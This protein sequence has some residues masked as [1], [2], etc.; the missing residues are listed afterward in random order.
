MIL[1]NLL[2]AMMAGTFA[3]LRTNAQLMAEYERAKLILHMEP[4]LGSLKMKEAQGTLNLNWSSTNE[5]RQAVL[6]QIAIANA[7][8]A[9]G[10]HV[11]RM[12]FGSM[13]SRLSGRDGPVYDGAGRASADTRRGSGHPAGNYGVAER[14]ATVNNREGSQ[15]QK[16]EAAEEKSRAGQRQRL[17]QRFWQMW[18][19]H[20][21]EEIYP[22][23]LHILMPASNEG[24]AG[25]VSDE[26]KPGETSGGAGSDELSRMRRQLSKVEAMLEGLVE[27]M[28]ADREQTADVSSASQPSQHSTPNL[29][30]NFSKRVGSLLKGAVPQSESLPAPGRRGAVNTGPIIEVGGHAQSHRT[31]ATTSPAAAPGNFSFR[32]WDNRKTHA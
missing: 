8:V 6:N 12:S 10:R 20:P 3:R 21:P 13:I 16:P 18:Q 27:H 4:S 25:S 29:P 24:W 14:S 15:R 31:A 17:V 26:D 1:L 2:V 19:T 5:A 9:K 30:T 22:K 7:P 32:I 11:R 28:A 23:W